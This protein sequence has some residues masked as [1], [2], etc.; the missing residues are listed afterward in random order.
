MHVKYIVVGWLERNSIC[1]GVFDDREAANNYAEYRNMENDGVH[2]RVATAL[3]N[4]MTPA[5]RAGI[6]QRVSFWDNRKCGICG[7]RDIP[8]GIDWPVWVQ[9]RPAHFDC[10][11]VAVKKPPAV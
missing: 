3:Y 6:K 9:G 4:P 10:A 8:R 5:Q 11:S 1:S 2:Y 7:V